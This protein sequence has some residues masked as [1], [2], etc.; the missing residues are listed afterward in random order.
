MSDITT[1]DRFAQFQY[2][3]LK[4][5]VQGV[6][7]L[8]GVEPTDQQIGL[9][10]QAWDP[11]ARVAVS[12]C[13]G[14]GKTATLSWLTYL[15]L[16][17]QYD[18]RILVTSPSFQQLTRVYKTECDKWKGKMDKPFADLF[19]VTREKVALQSDK[20]VQQADLVTASTD[21]KENLQGG[22]AENYVILGDEASAIE[23]E[24]FATLQKTLSTG[25]G[26]R[27]ILTSNPTRSVGPFYDIFHKEELDK[28]W[29][30]MYFSAFDCPHTA[31]GFIE[32]IKATY[33]EDSDHYRVGVLGI[34][35]KAAATQFI[36][37]EIVD[38]AM[39]TQHL[40]MAYY[41]YPV[42][43]G[44][45]VARFGD[46]ETVLVARQGPKVIAI[47]RH[48]KL[49]TME[50]ATAVFEFQRK[51]QGKVIFVDAIGIGAGVFDRCKQLKM[52][53]REVMGS[54]G[55]TKPIE[56]FNMRSQLWGEMRYWL[57]ND[58]DIPQ[59]DELRTQLVGMTYGLSGKM[60]IQLTTKKDIKRMG[61]K[62]P[63]LADAL[64]LTFADTVYGAAVRKA[65]ARKIRKSRY[66]YT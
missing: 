26:G 40:K 24:A 59:I 55:S 33:G 21:N 47:E 35:P 6:R 10:R 46:D 4:N 9:I 61:M 48:S 39:M 14:A 53:V 63:D 66:K 18:C 54:H 64:S 30:S 57:D 51:H 42:V 3:W 60:Q 52:P 12:S 28:I 29:H 49:D 45:D 19:T 20:L 62:S 32:E 31:E 27:F 11:K 34:F 8:F 58:A 38:R 44:V 22:H 43:I 1:T 16:L 7:D 36:S 2:E 25:T 56:Y 15:F 41:N 17:T 13:T 37:A 5:P 65:R 50:V 23:P